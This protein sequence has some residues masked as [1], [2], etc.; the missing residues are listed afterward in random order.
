MS[1]LDWWF[2]H[3]ASTTRRGPNSHITN[4]NHQLGLPDE[5]VVLVYVTTYTYTFV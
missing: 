5:N 1:G 4:T 3:L 2:S